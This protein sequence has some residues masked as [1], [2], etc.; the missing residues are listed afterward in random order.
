MKKLDE[1]VLYAGK[2]VQ[3]NEMTFASDDGNTYPWEVVRRRNNARGVVVV[4]EML[5]SH[6]IVLLRQ[7]RQPLENYIIGFPAGLAESENLEE[8]ALREL[9]EETGY[10]GRVLEIGPLIRSN[11]GLMN[12]GAYT[13]RAVIDETD[14]R[15]EKPRQ[16]LEVSEEIEVLLV[17]KQD[18]RAFILERRALGD[19]IG[20]GVWYRFGFEPSESKER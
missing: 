20:M 5:P 11:P 6:R 13:V 15:N 18:I 10:Y 1:K 7:Y 12:E 2:W 19:D 9:R 17:P 3:L 14:P 8:E 16:K 4:A